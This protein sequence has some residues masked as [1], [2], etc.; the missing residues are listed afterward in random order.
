MKNVRL[1]TGS[2]ILNSST[3][4]NPFLKKKQQL[5]LALLGDMGQKGQYIENSPFRTFFKCEFESVLY[6][7]L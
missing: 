7:M 5:A 6:R 1:C 2:G 3:T 4:S